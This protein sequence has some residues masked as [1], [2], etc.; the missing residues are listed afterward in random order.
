MFEKCRI[1]VY[2]ILDN[3][4]SNSNNNKT[5]KLQII[6][7][8]LLLLLF[9]CSVSMVRAVILSPNEFGCTNEKL[10]KQVSKRERDYQTS[11]R[12]FVLI[13][14]SLVIAC[15]LVCILTCIY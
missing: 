1:Y 8:K 15:L 10:D 4:Y 14:Y 9:W 3:K 12:L 6:R 2:V 5:Q 13:F 11:Y 7:S